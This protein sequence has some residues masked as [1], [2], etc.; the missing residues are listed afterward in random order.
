MLCLT[1]LVAWMVFG[2]SSMASLDPAEQSVK[3]F[4]EEKGGMVETKDGHIVTVWCESANLQDSDLE[5]F[6]ALPQLSALYLNYNSDIT[7]DVFSMFDNMP[8]LKTLELA[9]TKISQRAADKFREVHPEMS[10]SGP[11]V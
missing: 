5:Q 2:C 8:T 6:A 7:N 1:V 10:V 11:G 3:S 4:V 9:E